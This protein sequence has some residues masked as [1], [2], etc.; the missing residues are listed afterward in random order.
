MITSSMPPLSTRS[1]GKDQHGEGSRV[2]ELEK[3]VKVLTAQNVALRAT[4]DTM[5]QGAGGG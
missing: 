2:E 5:P 3:K 1:E 4:L